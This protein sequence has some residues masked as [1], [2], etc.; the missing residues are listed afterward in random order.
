MILSNEIKKLIAFRF[1]R[2]I[3]Y[4]KDC[5]ALA[6]CIYKQCNEPIGV[7]TLKRLYG[8]AKEIGEP[9]KSTLNIIANY[10][11]VEDWD[12]L[13]SGAGLRLQI[14]RANL[15]LL[16]EQPGQTW[17]EF[18]D[19]F[20]LNQELNFS[21]QTRN[22]DISKVVSLCEELGGYPQIFPFLIGLVE[23]ASAEKNKLFFEAI[24]ELPN[25]FDQKKHSP[26]NIYYLGQSIGMAFRKD[27]HL[28]K[29][30]IDKLLDN[31]NARSF[32]IEWFVDEDFLDGYY[33]E[34][35][36]RLVQKRV[37]KPLK[38]FIH[39]M[40]YK[41]ALMLK[42]VLEAERIYKRIVLFKIEEDIHE[43]LMGRYLAVKFLN[44]GKGNDYQVLIET[45]RS[46][47]QKRDSRHVIA[48]LF[49]LCKDLILQERVKAFQDVMKI[50][51]FY[52]TN[53]KMP[54]LFHWEKRVL[55]GIDLL[56][57]FYLLGNKKRE[58]AKE[59]YLKVDPRKF[60]IFHIF[61][62]QELYNRVGLAISA[63]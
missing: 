57:C 63:H 28:V 42:D 38:L 23:L 22:I 50:V 43:I 47:I 60:E 40:L 1:G 15:V 56:K 48:F 34:M 8:F 44:V 9:R 17:N 20:Q 62:M 49:Y 24:F 59:L 12:A 25:V 52:L 45:V 14:D 53:Q 61:Q 58:E 26:Y 7:T 33:G 19:V 2:T 35:L 46:F 54:E 39:I 21:L 31:S 18:I 6:R 5:E 16:R 10:V 11:G 55:N 13:K 27:S 36:I 3:E 51:D 32:M 37:D 41:R 4:S 29:A 30:V